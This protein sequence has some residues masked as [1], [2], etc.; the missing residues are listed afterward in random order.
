MAKAGFWMQGAKG[1]MAG[2]VFQKGKKGTVQR[3]NVTPKN[4]KTNL[5]MA[6][7]IIFATVTQAAKYMYPI[8]SH[9]FEGVAAGADSRQAFIK[10]NVSNL[11]KYAAYDFENNTGFDESQAYFTTKKVSALIP[12]KY[13]VSKGSL[14][15]D[16]IYWEESFKSAHAIKVDDSWV[17]EDENNYIIEVPGVVFAKTVLGITSA[18]EQL[19][20]MQILIGNQDS[21]ILFRME[22]NTVKG[23]DAI[24]K[25]KFSADRLVFNASFNNFLENNV[26]V[27]RVTKDGQYTSVDGAIDSFEDKINTEKSSAN[28]IS[29]IKEMNTNLQ[30]GY[31][32]ANKELVI[33]TEANISELNYTTTAG[34]VI[35]SKQVGAEWQR[36]TCELNVGYSSDDTPDVFGLTHTYAIPA[37]FKT[38]TIAESDK[39]LNEGG[40]ENQIP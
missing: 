20:F 2:A 24:K 8:I 36:N 9:S 5:Q 13:I 7:R 17:S 34:G 11:R 3:V 25:A 30:A 28:A 14:Q 12:N 35:L 33:K 31:S 26:I 4:P 10:E 38:E 40:S 19:T 37:W 6:Q 22:N 39:F 1:K 21:D 27:L 32:A 23:G 15:Y 16:A 18:E 29:V